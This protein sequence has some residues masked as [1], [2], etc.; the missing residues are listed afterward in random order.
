[1]LRY[2]IHS[3]CKKKVL[4][5]VQVINGVLCSHE[6]KLGHLQG[7]DATGNHH[8]REISQTQKYQHHIFSHMRTSMQMRVVYIH[9]CVYVGQ[10]AGRRL[11]T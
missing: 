9:V 3:K 10:Q 8:V 7:I 2:T 11:L 1:M 6:E 5:M 4:I